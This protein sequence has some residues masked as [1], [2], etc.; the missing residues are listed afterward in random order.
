M[1]E[2]TN[3]CTGVRAPRNAR[4]IAATAVSSVGVLLSASGAAAFSPTERV[5]L[6]PLSDSSRVHGSA[7]VGAHGAGT[8]ASVS[9]SGLR[10][11]TAV[12]VLLQSGTC[13]RHGAS[14]AVLVSGRAGATGA[15]RATGAARFHGQPVGY[16]IV[17]DG[18]H[19][20][21]VVVAGRLVAC[22]VIPGSS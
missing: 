3:R 5:P 20:I 17:A 9:L 14:F 2:T 19:V 11:G 8:R 16:G 15:F 12:R 22:G 4:R 6:E 10:R 21:T 1:M 13:R 18:A 7:V